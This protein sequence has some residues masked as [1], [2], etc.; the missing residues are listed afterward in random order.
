MT[1]A[2]NT[3]LSVILTLYRL[4]VGAIDTAENALR[5][6]LAQVGI[7][8]PVQELI[9]I[10]VAILFVV[11]ALQLFGRVF[12]VLIALFLILVLLHGI[13]AHH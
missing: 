8:G 6:A 13:A 7:G 1:Q 2:A 10:L 11:A 9:L 12:A 5:H 3:I 4:I